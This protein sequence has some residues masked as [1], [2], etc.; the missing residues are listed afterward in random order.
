MYPK[1]ESRDST[2]QDCHTTRTNNAET[3]N[4]AET[5]HITL[6]KSFP[7]SIITKPSTKIRKKLKKK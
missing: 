4:K 5:P 1:T 6:S 7:K 3:I 2:A